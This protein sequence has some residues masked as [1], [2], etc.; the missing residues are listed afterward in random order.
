MKLKDIQAIESSIHDLKR[1]LKMLHKDET[2]IAT[3]STLS[4]LP[5]DTWI[6]KQTGKQAIAFNKNVGSE[7][8]YLANAIEKLSNLIQKRPI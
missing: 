3:L 2:I 1:A 8:C 5:D 6:N 4:A 7:L